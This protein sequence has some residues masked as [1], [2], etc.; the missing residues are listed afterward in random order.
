MD[1]F[2]PFDF[3]ISAAADKKR[4]QRRVRRA[5]DG[6][7]ETSSRICDHPGCD[8]K[9]SFRAPKSPDRLDQFHWFCRKH[10]REYNLRWDYFKGRL[11]SVDGSAAN[12]LSEDGNNSDE[13]QQHRRE[14]RAWQRL[15][16]D[17]P[18]EILGEKGTPKPKS[19]NNRRAVT[20]SERKALV[21][22]DAVDCDSIGEIRKR[23]ISL[24]K[25]FHPDMNG[26]DRSEEHKLKEVVWA[27][28]QIKDSRNFKA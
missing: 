2:D 16:I 21:I 24:V 15:G 27:W 12:D 22:L 26:G 5:A 25:I 18:Y 8:R 17:D 10:V 3:D 28:D 4:R 11:G 9:G 19:R 1:K 14:M 20:A 23:Y 13:D 6:S 7:V